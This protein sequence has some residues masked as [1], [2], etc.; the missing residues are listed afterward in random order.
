MA[1]VLQYDVEMLMEFSLAATP[2]SG[3]ISTWWT[4]EGDLQ[5]DAG[6]GSKTWNGTRFGDKAIMRISGTQSSSDTVSSRVLIQVAVGDSADVTRHS[7]LARDL[8]PFDVDLYWIPTGVGI[9]RCMGAHPAPAEGA[10]IQI[11][12]RGRDLGVRNRE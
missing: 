6:T 10:H 2:P 11:R 4:G 8:G 12:I 7:I 9:G 3:F 5:F 1:A